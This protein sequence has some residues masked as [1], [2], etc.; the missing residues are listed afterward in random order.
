[1][2]GY[3]AIQASLSSALLLIS[4]LVLMKDGCQLGWGKLKDWRVVIFGIEEHKRSN[5][6][7]PGDLNDAPDDFGSEVLLGR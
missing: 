4:F 5:N 6:A 3:C 1:M 2:T 7:V